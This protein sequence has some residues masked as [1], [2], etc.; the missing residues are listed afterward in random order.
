VLVLTTGSVFLFVWKF[1]ILT[2][3]SIIIADIIPVIYG[4]FM[5]LTSIVLFL[6]GLYTM[7]YIQ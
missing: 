1:P 7:I 2:I 5:I 6:L 4:Y 3:Y